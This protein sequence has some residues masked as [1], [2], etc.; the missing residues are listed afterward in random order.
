MIRYTQIKD[1]R[2]LD[3]P[4]GTIWKETGIDS[5]IQPEDV[6]LRSTIFGV[7]LDL[8]DPEDS[9]IFEPLNS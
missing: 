2:W 6:L 9:L 4:A 7:D 8:L 3:T 5:Y 1:V